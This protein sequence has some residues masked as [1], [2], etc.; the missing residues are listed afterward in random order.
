MTIE[1]QDPEEKLLPSEFFVSEDDWNLLKDLEANL[2]A[3]IFAMENNS[4]G[5][6]NLPKTGIIL[7]CG[8]ASQVPDGWKICDGTNGL[9]DLR[10]M[11]LMGAE[12][13]I[14]VLSTGGYSQHC[15]DNGA[16]SVIGD[17]SHSYS[18]KTGKPS[19]T[20]NRQSPSASYTL[21]ANST[22]TH[23]TSTRTTSQAGGHKHSLGNTNYVSNLP[24]Y[25]RL[26][27]IGRID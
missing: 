18:V 26:Y 10:G 1:W 15:H 22:H 21:V 17:H 3:R 4:G 11:F 5:D 2:N 20:I 8:L 27:Y 25:K 19:S 6:T 9:P 12:S 16:V 23:T 24:P 14:E 7:W 13:D